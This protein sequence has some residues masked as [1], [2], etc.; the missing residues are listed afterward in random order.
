LNWIERKNFH[1][2]T[3]ESYF[4]VFSLFSFYTFIKLIDGN[5]CDGT[6]RKVEGKIFSFISLRELGNSYTN[7]NVFLVFSRIWP[8]IARLTGAKLFR[9]KF[10][11]ALAVELSH[12]RWSRRAIDRVRRAGRIINILSVLIYVFFCGWYALM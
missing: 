2:S 1:T 10:L 4:L 11:N 6:A 12:V 9:R 3:L 5:I 7:W 8:A